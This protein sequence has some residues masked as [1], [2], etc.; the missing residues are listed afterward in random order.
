MNPLTTEQL[1]A[2]LHNPEQTNTD[3]ELTSLR[4]TLSDLRAA[5]IATVEHHHQHA[6]FIP[7]RNNAARIWTFATAAL[8]L[9][10]AAPVAL[11]H[12]VTPAA[13]V[14]VAVQQPAATVSDDVLFAN[15]QADL[16]AS[17]PSPLLP[18][19]TD[20]TTNSTSTKDTQ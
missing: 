1:D 17:V 16:D 12:R 19:S 7:T 11:H 8:I 10:A 14:A 15:V 9:C 13:P 5:T 3:A 18:L 2:L 20:T 6:R 4:A